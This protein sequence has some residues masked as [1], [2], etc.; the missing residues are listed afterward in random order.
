ML[1]VQATGGGEA[2]ADSAD[3]EGRAA[4]HAERS[5]A[6]RI[7]ALGVQVMLQHAAKNLPYLVE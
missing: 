1:G 3:C 2:L 7:D 4:Q 5:I 6:E